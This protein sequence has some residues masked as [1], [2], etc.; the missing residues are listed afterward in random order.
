[1]Y[2]GSGECARREHVHVAAG[3][4]LLHVPEQWQGQ[5]PVSA[6]HG[7]LVP[8]VGVGRQRHEGRFLPALIGT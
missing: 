1:L 4:L 2:T 7:H 3:K 5:L 8:N 6:Y